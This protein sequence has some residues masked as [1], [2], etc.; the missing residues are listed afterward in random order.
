M[1]KVDH[2]MTVSVSWGF[3]RD[4]R[5]HVEFRPVE[6]DLFLLDVNGDRWLR[7]A[8]SESGVVTYARVVE[9]DVSSEEV[10]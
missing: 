9:S 6:N 5:H 8:T 7:V 10:N 1:I 3:L 4:K 2:G